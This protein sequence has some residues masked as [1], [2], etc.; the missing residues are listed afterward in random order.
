MQDLDVFGRADPGQSIQQAQDLLTIP[1]GAT[2]QLAD[3]E[4]VCQ[5][6]PLFEK[7]AERPAAS[8]EMIHPNGGVN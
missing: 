5:D 3:D 7:K 2:C 1:H 8:A 4:W 6:P